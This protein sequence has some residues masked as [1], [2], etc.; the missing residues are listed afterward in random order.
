MDNGIIDKSTIETQPLGSHILK[1]LVLISVDREKK[2]CEPYYEFIPILKEDFPKDI[3]IINTYHLGEIIK[4][5]LCRKY[6]EFNNRAPNMVV[7]SQFDRQVDI[8]LSSNENLKNLKNELNL[9]FIELP[10]ES[11]SLEQ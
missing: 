10:S 2:R 6:I 11:T 5:V 8:L 3:N 1:V 4:G 9:N 7:L